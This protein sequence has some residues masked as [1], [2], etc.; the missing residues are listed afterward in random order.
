[1]TKRAQRRAQQQRRRRRAA[2]VA[3]SGVPGLR[4]ADEVQ[5]LA[6]TR[7]QAA[8]AL[9]VSVTTLDRRVVPL[10][11]TIKTPW[12]ARLIPARELERLLERHVAPAA[13]AVPRRRGRPARIAVDVVERIWREHKAGESLAA[14]ARRLTDDGVATAHGGRR[15]WPS[16]I[17]HVLETCEQP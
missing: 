2:A 13:G 16:T 7:R 4:L 9:G 11:E 14:I 10:I 1:L 5:R 15:W 8:A 17:R 6:Y 12:G 3:D